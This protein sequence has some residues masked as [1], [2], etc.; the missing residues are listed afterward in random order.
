MGQM[1]QPTVSKHR[2]TMISQQGQGSIPPGSA[3]QKVKKM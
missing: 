2:R 3:H 1:T